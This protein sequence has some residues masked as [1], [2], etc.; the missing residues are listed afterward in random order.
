VIPLKHFRPCCNAAKDHA[1]AQHRG[2]KISA[3]EHRG[4]G[5][6]GGWPV[7]FNA[8]TDFLTKLSFFEYQEVNFSK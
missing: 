7:L 2:E 1:A 5:G 3:L 8:P 6:M 4:K